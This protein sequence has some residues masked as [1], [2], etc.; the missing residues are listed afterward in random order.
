MNITKGWKKVFAVGCSHGI[1][2]DRKALEAVIKFRESFKP[3]TCVHLG[4]F[5][6][7]SCFMSSANLA[8]QSEAPQP[9]VDGGIEFLNRLRPNLILCG[10]HEDRLWRLQN[11]PNAIVSHA[12]YDIIKQITATA[13]TLRAELVPYGGVFQQRVIGGVTYTHG[14][15]YNENSPRDMAEMYGNV[16]FAHTHKVGTAKGRRA[17]SPTGYCVGT[18]TRRAALDYAKTRRA[19]LAWSQGFVWGYYCGDQ[20][21]L[22][23]HE[24]NHAFGEWILPR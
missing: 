3:D 4:D 12:A 8:N 10:N 6:D 19:T 11:S 13:K 15:V 5:T 17:D 18:L 2:A 9:D 7:L 16:V 1:H 14:T 20:S 24:H 23:L 22:W 21:Q